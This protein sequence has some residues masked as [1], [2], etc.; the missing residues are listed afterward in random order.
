MNTQIA[1]S[2]ILELCSLNSSSCPDV[3]FIYFLSVTN[4]QPYSV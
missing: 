2:E 4:S 3:F 1:E